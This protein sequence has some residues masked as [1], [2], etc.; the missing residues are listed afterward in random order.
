MN[1]I[2]VGLLHPMAYIGNQ[3][4]QHAD[5]RTIPPS[6]NPGTGKDES[7]YGDQGTFAPLSI[8]FPV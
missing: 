7:S 5:P 2:E 3:R 1:T 6:A 4:A 8:V